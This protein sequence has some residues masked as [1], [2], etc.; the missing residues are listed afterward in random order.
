MEAAP[1]RDLTRRR[2][3]LL[4]PPCLD[5]ESLRKGR[6]PAR[7]P[8]ALRCL[9]PNGRSLW[10]SCQNSVSTALP[11]LQEKENGPPGSPSPATQALGPC[12]ELM[13]IGMSDPLNT[14]RNPKS[15]Q[16][17]NPE[18][19]S[20][21]SPASLQRRPRK[22]LNPRMGIEKVDP[23]F[24]G[25]TL[26]FQ[27]QPDSSLQIVPTYSLP[28][29]SCLQR[30]PASPSKALVS[31]GGNEALGPRRCASCRTQRTPL[32]RDAEDGTPL[33]NACGIRYKKYGTRCSSCW[34]V[35]RKSVQP[36]RLCGRCGVSQDSHLNPA[37]EL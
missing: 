6:P 31:P 8:G 2:Q 20:V 7:E 3:Q 24:K 16:C 27:I 23:R 18:P 11:Y 12:W 35:P 19:S 14:V 10:P 32:W 33:C 36:K 9:T 37:Q 28:G 26:E 17:P 1:A 29:R 5:T 21:A 30:L 13:V 22:Q 34:L 25:V 15:T 4:A